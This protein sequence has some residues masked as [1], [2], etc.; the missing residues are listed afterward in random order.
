VGEKE[1]TRYATRWVM[2]R[3]GALALARRVAREGER[4]GENLGRKLALTGMRASAIFPLP[5]YF[6]EIL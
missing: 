1:R 4:G 6:S 2:V 5:P 3:G